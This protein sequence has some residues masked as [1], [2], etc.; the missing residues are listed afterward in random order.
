MDMKHYVIGEILENGEIEKGYSEQGM[1]YKNSKAFYE[2][3]D[4][5]CYVPESHDEGYKYEDFIELASG[6]DFIAKI[7]FDSV[8]WQ[9][10]ETLLEEWICEDEVHICKGC[11]NMYVSYEVEC[12]PKCNLKKEAG[13][14]DTKDELKYVYIVNNAEIEVT[15]YKNPLEVNDFKWES[16]VFPHNDE[17]FAEVK[18]KET[19]EVLRLTTEGKVKIL[20][21]YEEEMMSYDDISHLFKTAPPCLNLYNTERYRILN[22]NWFCLEFIDKNEHLIEDYTFESMPKK[23]EELV[24]ILVKSHSEFF[25]N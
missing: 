15:L 14:I 24:D 2:K 11:D 5:I 13:I 8:D 7:L 25:N 4:E 1:I 22:N 17:V 9:D 21:T 6:N 12:C 23:Y 16:L 3:L 10:P 18:N 20:D 19:L